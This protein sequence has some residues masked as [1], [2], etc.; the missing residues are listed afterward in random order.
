MPEEVK[1]EI[2]ITKEAV[3][4][5]GVLLKAL[6]PFPD[7][8]RRESRE[9]STR[10]EIKEKKEINPIDNN[11]DNNNSF[12]VNVPINNTSK[13]INNN[14]GN[15]VN[16]KTG[17]NNHTTGNNLTA[18]NSTI[19]T[20]ENN[21]IIKANQE[22]SLKEIIDYIIEKRYS[23]DGNRFYNYYKNNNWMTK[24]GNS[25]ISNWKSYIDSWNES[26]YNRKVSPNSVGTDSVAERRAKHPFV[27]SDL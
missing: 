7:R 21:N 19:N 11:I 10:E 20:K 26:Q 14:I 13:D 17:N 16:L 2:T 18:T 1:F 25:I 15:G 22:P 3:E 4:A 12:C 24:R 8:E 23:V 6:F 27:P 5:I 9:E